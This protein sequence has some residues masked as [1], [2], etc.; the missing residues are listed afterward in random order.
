MEEFSI[1]SVIV[2]IILTALAYM[3]FP[4]IKMLF[5]NGTFERKRAKSRTAVRSSAF[6]LSI[7]AKQNGD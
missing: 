1:Q 4:L 5:S 2:S 3:A 7:R 6:R